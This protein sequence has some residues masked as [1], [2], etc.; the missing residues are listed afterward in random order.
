MDSSE[1]FF[2]AGFLT[3]VCGIGL[4][5]AYGTKFEDTITVDDKFTEVKGNKETTTHV[6]CVSDTTGKIYTVCPSLAYLQFN[7]T[8]IWNSLK[9]EQKYNI[10]GYGW[11][12]G[13][14]GMYPNII[15]AELVE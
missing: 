5:Y 11:R 2:T 9:K 12:V 13:F 3:A 15:K 7:S 14:F 1:L 8:E 10:T 6:H 4:G